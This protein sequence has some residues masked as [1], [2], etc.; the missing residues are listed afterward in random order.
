MAPH[1][2]RSDVERLKRTQPH[3][4]SASARRRCIVL[5]ALARFVVAQIGAIVGTLRCWFVPVTVRISPVPRSVSSLHATTLARNV[6]EVS[7]QNV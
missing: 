1:R 4:A 2:L 7:P 6:L 5:I 3:L